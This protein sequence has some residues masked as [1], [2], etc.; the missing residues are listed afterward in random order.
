MQ[1]I[2]IHPLSFS[3]NLP[4][5]VACGRAIVREGGS[6]TAPFTVPLPGDTLELS[7]CNNPCSVGIQA[8][9]SR[10]ACASRCICSTSSSTLSKRRS[11]RRYLK[12]STLACLP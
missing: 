7:F 1:R 9:Y 4:E 5:N 10:A 11:G 3:G 12:N 2:L 6:K 8:K